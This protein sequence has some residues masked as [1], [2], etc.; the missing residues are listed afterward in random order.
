[1]KEFFVPGKVVGQ[2]RISTI[3]GYSFHSNAK[4]LLPWREAV[5]WSA[6]AAR[7]PLIGK[8]E[9]GDPI[10]VILTVSFI[11]EKPKSVKRPFPTVAPDLDHYVRAIGDSLKG[12]AYLDDS[13]IC[14]T[15]SY[16]EYGKTPGVRIFVGV[17]DLPVTSG[18]VL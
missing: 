2:G 3:N 16:K 14:E 11:L 10:P 8:N 7:L 4:E 5:A 15:H 18:N 12:I 6:K 1:M 13:Q 9:K 17:I